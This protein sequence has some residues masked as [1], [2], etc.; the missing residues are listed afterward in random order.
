VVTGNVMN[1][2][3]R[4]KA[5]DSDLE[6]DICKQERNINTPTYEILDLYLAVAEAELVILVL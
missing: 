4:L 5:T 3:I 1:T 2:F 6:I